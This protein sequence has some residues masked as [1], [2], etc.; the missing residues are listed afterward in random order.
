M[1]LSSDLRQ[2]YYDLSEGKL[3]TNTQL[4]IICQAAAILSENDQLTYINRCSHEWYQG[5]CV[6]CDIRVKNGRPISDFPDPDIIGHHEG[7]YP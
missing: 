6:H 3:P 7:K 2:L 4:V 1:S 5:R